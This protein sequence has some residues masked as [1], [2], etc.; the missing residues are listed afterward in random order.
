MLPILVPRRLLL[1]EPRLREDVV[2][3]GK[4]LLAL[5]GLS[6]GRLDDDLLLRLDD[7][8]STEGD[9]CCL[10]CRSSEIISL[11]DGRLPDLLV[12][13]SDL[14]FFTFSFR[15]KI[16]SADDDIFGLWTA[17]MKSSSLMGLKSGLSSSL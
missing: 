12:L 3:L 8:D 1:L 15:T 14:D 7:V 13:F 6:G 11:R 2:R 10:G 4:D 9:I 16:E 5:P 17:P